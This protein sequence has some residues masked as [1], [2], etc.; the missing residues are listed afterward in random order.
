MILGNDVFVFNLDV[1]VGFVSINIFNF[2]VVFFYVFL[3]LEF[4]V[5]E[6]F[7]NVFIFI[8]GV[9]LDV[10]KGEFWFWVCILLICWVYWGGVDLLVEWS[11]VLDMVLRVIFIVFKMGGIKLVGVEVNWIEVLC[12]VWSDVFVLKCL[13]WSVVLIVFGNWIWF[14]VYCVFIIEFSCIVERVLIFVVYGLLLGF[15]MNFFVMG[16]F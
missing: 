2:W 9:G 3:R 10:N 13:I 16:F 8:F 4:I 1:F 7:L 15:E 12:C 11:F 5:F 6:F 14:F